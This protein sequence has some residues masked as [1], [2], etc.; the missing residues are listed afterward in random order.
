MFIKKE[1][2]DNLCILTVERDEALNAINPT[3]LNELHD[4]ISKLGI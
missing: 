2:K 1:L 4:N 3:V